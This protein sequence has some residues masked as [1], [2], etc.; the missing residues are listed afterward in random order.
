MR[1]VLALAGP[2]WCKG[3]R[4]VKDVQLCLQKQRWWLA[5][6]PRSPCLHEGASAAHLSV[7]WCGETGPAFYQPKP[8]FPCSV[9][10]GGGWSRESRSLCSASV[11]EGW[12]PP[13]HALCPSPCWSPALGVLLQS[14]TR[15][16]PTWLPHSGSCWQAGVTPAMCTQQDPLLAP[17][18][19]SGGSWR[20]CASGQTEE[21]EGQLRPALPKTQEAHF[22]K[23]KKYNARQE[24]G[25]ASSQALPRISWLRIAARASSTVSAYLLLQALSCVLSSTP[26][27]CRGE[28][29]DVRTV[30]PRGSSFA[31]GGQKIWLPSSGS[32]TDLLCG[33]ERVTALPWD[34]FLPCHV[35]RT[36]VP[37]HCW[38]GREEICCADLSGSGG[39]CTPEQS[40]SQMLSQTA[41]PLPSRVLPACRAGV[42]RRT[43]LKLCALVTRTYSGP[44]CHSG[45]SRATL[46]TAPATVSGCRKCLDRV[47]D[48]CTCLDWPWASRLSLGAV[49]AL[50]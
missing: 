49:R 11:K 18:C 5:A 38:M 23:G 39:S 1:E 28:S 2:C 42:A 36:L 16:G 3:S 14:V 22:G 17:R 41:V 45:A 48:Q 35:G 34:G 47:W 31:L 6:L 44:Y 13:S 30:Q 19:G 8:G 40:H 12:S 9:S 50:A 46:A 4:T 33:L 32:A 27:W 24:G 29:S 20:A 15:C 25:S 7:S 10:C 43:G 21:G 26:T 37:C